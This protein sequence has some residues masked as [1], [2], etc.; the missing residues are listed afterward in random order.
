MVELHTL[1]GGRGVVEGPEVVV[2]P[3]PEVLRLQGEL[4]GRP[5]QST[6]TIRKVSQQNISSFHNPGAFINTFP[7]ALHV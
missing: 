6:V 3:G 1:P 2:R 7:K 4:T 5:Q